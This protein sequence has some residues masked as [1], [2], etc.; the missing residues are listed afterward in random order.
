MTKQ[1][2]PKSTPHPALVI[3]ALTVAAI[4]IAAVFWM[5]AAINFEIVTP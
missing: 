2:D 4:S 3:S 5:L 1:A